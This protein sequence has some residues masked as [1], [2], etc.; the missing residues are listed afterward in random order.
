MGDRTRL[1]IISSLSLVHSLEETPGKPA[2]T[3]NQVTLWE[4][5]RLAGSGRAH[6]VLGCWLAA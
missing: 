2:L 4:G 1:G 3:A 5:L 6:A